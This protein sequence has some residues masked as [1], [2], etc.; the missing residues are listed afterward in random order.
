MKG[1]DYGNSSGF[2]LSNIQLLREREK[3]KKEKKEK[4]EVVEVEEE[5]DNKRRKVLSYSYSYISH[6]GFDFRLAD[7]PSQIWKRG[8]MEERKKRGKHG[9]TPFF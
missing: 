4:K 7:V 9:K 2:H 1:R 5:E 8:K 3:E 6:P